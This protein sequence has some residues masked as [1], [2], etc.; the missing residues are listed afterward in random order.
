MEILFRARL[1]CISNKRGT[2]IAGSV[3]QQCLGF[4]ILEQNLGLSLLLVVNGLLSYEYFIKT[5]HTRNLEAS[6]EFPVV[7]S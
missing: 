1:L 6:W 2:I 3:K 4:H 5:I 7:N